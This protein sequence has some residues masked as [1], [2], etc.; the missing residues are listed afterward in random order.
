[1]CVVIHSIIFSL[2]FILVRVVL[3]AKPILG[4]LGTTEDTLD[5]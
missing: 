5:P 1:M 2:H 3:D 4:T